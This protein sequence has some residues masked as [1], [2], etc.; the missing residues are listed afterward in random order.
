MVVVV[1][2]VVGGGGYGIVDAI[3]F[4]ILLEYCRTLISSKCRV[5]SRN[6]GL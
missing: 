6:L 4:K 1:V 2:V 5:L 3:L